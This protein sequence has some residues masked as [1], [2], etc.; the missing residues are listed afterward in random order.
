MKRF[1]ILAVVV[2]A[3]LTQIVQAQ[4]RGIP[5]SVTSLAPGRQFLPGPSVTSLGPHGWDNSPVLLG[6]PRFNGRFIGGHNGFRHFHTRNVVP[7]FVPMYTPYSMGVYPMI[8]ADPSAGYDPSYAA[9]S[10]NVYQPEPNAVGEYE[11]RPPA[12]RRSQPAVSQREEEQ[13]V[14]TAEPE[15]AQA[16]STPALEAEPQAKTLLVFKDGHKLEVTNYVIQGQTLFNL[17]DNGPR[18]VLI[19]ELDLDKTVT[20]NDKHGVEFKLP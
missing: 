12:K 8:Y 6:N 10:S 2:L 4:V 1:I 5:P 20:E 14:A 13:Q 11:V 9:D 3:G 19:S 7:V 16:A 15:T 18:K 17:G